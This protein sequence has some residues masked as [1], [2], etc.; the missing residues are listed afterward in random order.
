[1]TPGWFFDGMLE[2]LVGAAERKP[3]RLQT[4]VA[5]KQGEEWSRLGSELSDDA[6]EQLFSVARFILRQ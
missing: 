6:L 4:F 5:S 3:T 1:V 2:A